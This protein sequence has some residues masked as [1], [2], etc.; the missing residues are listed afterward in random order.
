MARERTDMRKSREILRHI[1][2]LKLSYQVVEASLGVS[3]GLVCRTLTKARER[4]LAWPEIE[5][6]SDDELEALLYGPPSIPGATTTLPDWPQVDAQLRRPGVTLL[7]LHQEYRHEHPEGLGYSQFCDHYSRFRAKRPLI[8]RQSHVAGD[9]LFVDYSGKRPFYFD[10]ESGER[11]DCELFVA[12]L[13]ASNLTYAEAT[14]TQRSGDFLRS[15][16]RAHQ[17]L[18]GVPRLWVPDNLKSAVTR[19]CRY[20]PTLQSDYRELAAHYGAAVLPARPRKPRDKAKVEVGVQIAQRWL[21]AC[22]RNVRCFSL[23][24][25]NGHIARLLEALNHRPMRVYK[26]SR[27]ELF[28][29]LERQHLRPLPLHPFVLCETKEARV[30]ID[31]HV[32]LSGHYYSVPYTL[33]GE[34]VRLRA[35]ETTV[36]IFHHHKRVASHV[37]SPRRGAHSTC[38]EHM[39]KA[40]QKQ[41]DWSPGR[42]LSWAGKIG[43]HASSLCQAIL[44]DRRHP[45]QGYRSCL[46][47]IRLERRY[48]A[49]RIEAACERAF[50]AGARSYQSVKAILEGGLDRIPMPAAAPSAVRLA[51]HENLRGPDYYN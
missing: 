10:P 30:H 2:Q 36:E 43:P 13:G 47:L 27:R 29:K 19:S 46:G 1:L 44:Q 14:A 39:P 20:E 6:L 24:E 38:V 50:A 15:H 42:I 48:E 49:A 34:L 7:L 32:E 35:T 4:G 51:P 18:G 28:E 8:M 37:R 31:Y 11:I 3:H 5:P 9:K 16:I 45:E 33:V 21:L 22:L 23:A 25:L 26:C 40:H 12:V 17:Y 41:Q